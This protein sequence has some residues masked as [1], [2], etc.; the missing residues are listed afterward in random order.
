MIFVQIDNVSKSY[1]EKTLFD[2]IS[3]GIH[4]GH[5]IALIAKNG[6]GK[7]TLLKIIAGSETQNGGTIIMRN[8]LTY[9]YLDQNPV[10]DE[11]M[12]V[13]EGVFASKKGH[14]QIVKA[15]EE[16]LL[17]GDKNLLSV[18]TDAMDAQ[19][20]WAFEASAKQILGQLQ[21][22][23]LNKKIKELSGGQKKR[24]ALASVLI[25]EPELLLL[26]E[27]T[28]HLDLDMIVWLE[29]YLQSSNATLLMVTHDRY[30]LDRVCN[31]IIEMDDGRIFKYKGNYS[32]FLEKRDERIENEKAVVEKAK[33][34]MRKELD[35][36][37]RSPLARTTK[38]KSRIESFYDIKEIATSKRIEKTIKL[39]QKKQRLG[40][41]IMEIN[42]I[43]KSFE[44]NQL[45][46]NFN[47]TFKKNEKIGII[48]KNG[49]GKTTLLN[50]LKGNLLPDKGYIDIG[51][52]V[53]MGYYKQDG[54]Q[55]NEDMRV[56]DIAKEIAEV[57]KLN[58]GTKISAS[59]FLRQF[60]FTNEMQYTPVSKLSGGERR[61]LYL[62][63]ILIRNPNFLILDEPT[64]DLDIITL[65]ILED[66]LSNFNGCV[67]LVSHDRYFMDKI[68]EHLFVFEEHSVVKDFPGNYS[69][70]LTY[71]ERKDVQEKKLE[72]NKENTLIKE[73]SNDLKPK[74]L[75][76]K[77][78]KEYEQL[79][80]DI[81]QLEEE[82]KQLEEQLYEGKLNHEEVLVKS[83][84]MGEVINA[85]E[86]K[87]ERWFVLSIAGEK[88]V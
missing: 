43:S 58:D 3:F 25:S 75:T 77:E 52:T 60:L 10:F 34:I 9:E 6:S 67:L 69:Q 54:I 36:I 88:N 44:G 12:N 21:L 17:S 5:K 15:Y 22:T 40:K 57:V 8:G 4:K 32:Y 68:V 7:S 30:F 51:E 80:Q 63:T 87:T 64:N 78:Q 71:K 73:K 24:L 65:N 86:E 72:K 41:K 19:N 61:R 74:K 53:I 18:A 14:A 42:Y 11:E 56:I 48:G 37:R 20:A 29:K 39:E 79:E 2:N 33:N 45:F 31:E 85:I 26:D 1:N 70:Y 49:C 27:P 76:Y 59:E 46:E 55:F 16:A 62:M 82:K 81:N 83:A 35:W 28:N 66:Y 23:A 47:Y 50:I 13:L 84:R 38:S